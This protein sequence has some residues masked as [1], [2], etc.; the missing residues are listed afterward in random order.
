MGDFLPGYVTTLCSANLGKI[1][2]K[3][4]V[5]GKENGKL[6]YA[7]DTKEELLEK[8]RIRKTRMWVMCYYRD[9][10]FTQSEKEFLW[11]NSVALLDEG[12]KKRIVGSIGQTFS[13]VNL[14]RY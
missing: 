10:E 14:R 3:L 6:Y 9:I 12:Q 2:E 4:I 13:L 8:V 11:N 7:Y 5:I 1:Q